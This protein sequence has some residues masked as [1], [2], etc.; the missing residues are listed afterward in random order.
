VPGSTS[1]RHAYTPDSDLQFV[2]ACAPELE[3]YLMASVIYWPLAQPKGHAL[4]PRLTLGGLL[5][6]LHRLSAVERDLPAG[7]AVRLTRARTRIETERLRWTA[8]MGTKVAP[9]MQAHLNLW[10]A[11]LDDLSESPGPNA[12]LYPTEVRARAMLQ[13][14]ATSP[15]TV[16]LPAVARQAMQALDVR[17]REMFA[18]G[19]FVWEEQLAP[20]FSPPDYWFLYGRPTEKG[21]REG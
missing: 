4:L 18:A 12:D 15:E 10:R 21:E 7:Q 16:P 11:Y 19:S 5:L 1:P 20:A 14:L 17:L 2:E 9:E 13:L 6:A 8:A 3:A